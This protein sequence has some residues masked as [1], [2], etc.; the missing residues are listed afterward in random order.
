MSI[1]DL[2]PPYLQTVFDQ[3][4]LA[5]AEQALSARRPGESEQAHAVRIA[6]ED[7]ARR[8]RDLEERGLIHACM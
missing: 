1:R 2:F 8:R 4:E 7:R 5:Q 3:M 6:D